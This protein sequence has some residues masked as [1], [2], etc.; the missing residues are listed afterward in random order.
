LENR[1]QYLR[2]LAK[3][4]K[5]K[6]PN[7]WH[8]VRRADLIASGGGGL[9]VEYDSYIDLLKECIPELPRKMKSQRSK[10]ARRRS[11]PA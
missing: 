5:V 7:D 11:S 10:P 8:K 2:W 3:E 1:K 6:R 9:V 4:L